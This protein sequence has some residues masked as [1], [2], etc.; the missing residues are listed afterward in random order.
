MCGHLVAKITTPHQ[1]PSNYKKN[2]GNFGSE[3]S[4]R[5]FAIHQTQKKGV[6]EVNGR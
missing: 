1:I 3:N 6:S 4:F 5:S 2:D